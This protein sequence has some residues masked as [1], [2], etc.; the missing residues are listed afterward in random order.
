MVASIG[1]IHIAVEVADRAVR[2]HHRASKHHAERIIS[3]PLALI[4]N[5]LLQV[6]HP[7]VVAFRVFFDLFLGHFLE[8][9]FVG[10]LKIVGL[11]TEMEL[12]DVTPDPDRLKVL[13]SDVV[14]VSVILRADRAN[15]LD[16]D[17]IVQEYF[18]Y[19]VVRGW[20]IY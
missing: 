5:L 19:S 16:E 8:F 7:R 17:F 20:A 6:H 15:A 1:R 12:M 13:V 3:H 14:S 9:F 18:V 4:V 10:E 2:Q 11:Q